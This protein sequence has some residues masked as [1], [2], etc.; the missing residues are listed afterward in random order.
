MLRLVGGQVLTPLEVRFATVLINDDRIE[1]LAEPMVTDEKVETLDVS[2]CIVT[3]GLFDLQLNGGKS[4]DFWADPTEE[5][6]FNLCD[7]LKVEGV[8]SFL[9]TLIT[10]DLDR[11]N[12]N[13]SRLSSYGVGLGDGMTGN[14]PLRMP[15]IHLEGPCLSPER[16]GVH[17]K[18]Y[19]RDLKLDV[20]SKLMH[21]SVCLMTV[22]PE[23]DGGGEALS[24]L[25]KHGVTVS[26]GH[27]NATYDEAQS[28]F[29]NGVKLVTHTFNAMPPLHHRAPGAVAAAMLNEEVSC[30]LICDGLHLSPEIV[31]LVV[32]IKGV[33]KTILV[34]DAARIGTTGGGLVGSSISLRQ[35]VFN[36]VAWR[37]ATFPEAV[38]MATYNPA[39]ALGMHDRI[40]LLAPGNYADIVVW[41]ANTL[42]IRYV[43]VAGN[44]VHRSSAPAVAGKK[45]R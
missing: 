21:D 35:A 9:P 2:G 20:L 30:C 15:G 14:F 40:G 37:A 24:Y 34:T 38:R 5:E 1:A 8:T 44:I 18:N 39:A 26:L 22:A 3:P 42:A 17:P 36:M 4:C 7:D 32:K 31:R 33:G 13:I 23:T 41:E 27:S 28:A 16:P 12:K 45:A 10:D 25:A 11:L 29:E 6:I 19:I 43:I